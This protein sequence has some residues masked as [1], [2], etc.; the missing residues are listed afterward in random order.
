MGA[1]SGYVLAAMA[2]YYGERKIYGTDIV[3]LILTA[4]V[5]VFWAL[6]GDAITA[7]MA[8]VVYMIGF[9]PTIVRAWK[10][11]HKEGRLTFAMSVLKYSISF[12]LL[13]SVSIETAVYP[14]TL[15]VANLAFLVMVAS[16]RRQL[17]M[18]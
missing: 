13:G 10:A 7:I 6:D 11:P 8:T 17:A 1:I 2:W 14:V 3:S 4:L 12:V 18:L 15:A 16:R 5:L 9:I